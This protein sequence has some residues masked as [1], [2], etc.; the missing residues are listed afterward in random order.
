MGS[1]DDVF[2]KAEE[3]CNL[4]KYLVI[5]KLERNK[6]IQGGRFP[7]IVIPPSSIIVS[8][9]G[10][11]SIIATRNTALHSIHHSLRQRSLYHPLPYRSH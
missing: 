8:V 11:H 9:I 2:T 4:E 7:A 3:V 6:M 1:D 5:V 10:C